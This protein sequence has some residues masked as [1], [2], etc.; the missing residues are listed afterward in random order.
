M[1]IPKDKFFEALEQFFRNEYKKHPFKEYQDMIKK[2]WEDLDEVYRLAKE[3]GHL[4][5]PV[6]IG[7]TFGPFGFKIEEK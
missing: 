2:L 3:G 4:N 5:E 7:H 1:H 6:H